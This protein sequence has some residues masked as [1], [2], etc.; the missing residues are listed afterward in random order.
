MRNGEALRELDADLRNIFGARLRSLVAHGNQQRPDTPVA[1][2]ALVDV[3]TAAD[4][5]SCAA[6]AYRWH[7]QG[8]ATPL[9][10]GEDEFMRSL[11]AFPFEFGAILAD[12]ERVS[13]ADP[14]AALSVEPADLRRACEVQARSHLLHLREAYIETLGRADELADLIVR[15][16]AALAALLKNVALLSPAPPASEALVRVAELAPAGT[17]SAAEADRLFPEYLLG[18]EQLVAA[19]DRWRAA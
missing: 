4:L 13:G 5:R 9:I 12:Y 14:F 8:L 17:I 19:L 3:L 10:L 11:D 6:R 18:V 7:T 1:T 15:S 2:V 16:S